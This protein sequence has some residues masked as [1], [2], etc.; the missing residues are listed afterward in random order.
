MSTTNT[1]R[2]KTARKARLYAARGR[3]VVVRKNESGKKA[4]T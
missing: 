2:A 3:A 1:V 4:E